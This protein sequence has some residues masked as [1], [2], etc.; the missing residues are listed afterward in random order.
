MT[1]DGPPL[2]LRVHGVGGPQARKMLGELH[3]EDVVTLGPFSAQGEGE[4]RTTI[5]VSPETRFARR[6]HDDGTEA[7]EWG[8]LTTGSWAK[9]LWVVYLP[10]TLINAAGWAHHAAPVSGQRRRWALR[11]HLTA[12]H[13]LAALATTTYVLWVGYIALDLLGVRWRSHVLTEF[14]VTGITRD[15][16]NAWLPVLGPAVFL[17]LVGGLVLAPVLRGRFEEV[18]GAEPG[19]WPIVPSVASRS[20]F[21]MAAAHRH[22]QAVHLVVAAVVAVAVIGQSAAGWHRLG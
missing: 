10:F 19:P 6:L 18:G 8:G 12:V 22:R 13:V 9:A 17:A 20:F 14:E 11:L 21:A 2:E 1:V 3:E 4:N 7:Y 5:P 16:A 15:L